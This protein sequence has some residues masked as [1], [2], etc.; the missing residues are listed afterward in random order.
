MLFN[1]H[2]NYLVGEYCV[3]GD[4]KAAVFS[5]ENLLLNQY[6][7]MQMGQDMF[8]AVDTSYRYTTENVALMIV[9]VVS[10][11]QE[12][13]RVAYAVVNKESAEAHSVV[14]QIIREGVEFVVND[15]ISQGHTYV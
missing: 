9:F 12:G 7:Q 3:Q 8:F 11:N 14:F 13:H 4:I 15:R 10:L 5:T 6:R 1:E 2:T